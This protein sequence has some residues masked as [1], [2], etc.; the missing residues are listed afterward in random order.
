VISVRQLP[1]QG[2]SGLFGRP[3]LEVIAQVG[4]EVEGETKSAGAWSDAFAQAERAGGGVAAPE[5]MGS[6]ESQ[7]MEGA[8]EPESRGVRET[9]GVAVDLSDVLRRAGFS[10]TLR[11]RLQLE[12]EEPGTRRGPLHRQI[13][14]VGSR[15]RSLADAQA[16]RG[17][18]DRVA[19]VGTAG[20]GRTTA[21]L[22]WMARQAEVGR[23]LGRVVHVAADGSVPDALRAGAARA[24]VGVEAVDLSAGGVA[25]GR[26]DD[27]MVAEFP[28]LSL[29]DPVARRAQRRQLDAA[30][31]ST[32]VLVLNAL[33][34]GATLRR[35][36]A[37]GRD[38]GVTHVAFTHLDELAEWGRLWELLVE[39]EFSPLFLST[40]P[41]PTGQ[42]EDDVVAAVL[43]RT[44]PGN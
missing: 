2:L 40:G 16:G 27:R 18:T 35:V 3:R 41:S 13:A 39:G 23:S 14:A 19:F 30:G 17:V 29:T 20:A 6:E 32:R 43:R 42:R 26:A 44:V 8:A 38:L 24:G 22:K 4:G 28:A 31:L 9:E 33:H 34:D 10:E 25:A 37:A 12:L 21:L 36:A 5:S 1:G 11:S 7:A 15:L